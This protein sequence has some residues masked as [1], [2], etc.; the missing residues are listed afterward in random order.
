MILT[1]V[2][3]IYL[4]MFMPARSTSSTSSSWLAITGALCSTWR[5]T[6]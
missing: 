3:F 5:L 1:R 2:N 4:R 6:M